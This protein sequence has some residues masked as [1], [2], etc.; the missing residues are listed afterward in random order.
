METILLTAGACLTSDGIVMNKCA[1]QPAECQASELFRSAAWL[2][3]NKNDFFVQC[4]KQEK[5]R[6]LQSMGRCNSSADRYICTSHQASCRFSAVFEAFATDCNLVVDSFPSNEFVNAHYGFCEDLTA[7][8]DFCAWSFKECGDPDLWEWNIADPFFA[9][10]NPD[11]H[12]DKV[13]T[14]ACVNES[15]NDRFCAVTK[16]SCGGDDGFIYFGVLELEERFQVTCKLCDTIPPELFLEPTIQDQGYGEFEVEDSSDASEASS[17][18]SNEIK[19]VSG[20]DSSDTESLSNGAIVG[21]TIGS[22]AFVGLA[23]LGLIRVKEKRSS[24]V[25]EANPD[26]NMSVGTLQSVQ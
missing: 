17:E 26:D 24:G 21:I 12:C 11:C 18:I 20:D 3:E 15:T 22:V 7:R 13:K 16:E 9:N 4:S 23:I 10:Q 5:L 1:L 2:Y 14:G 6:E 8:N 25:E 19:S